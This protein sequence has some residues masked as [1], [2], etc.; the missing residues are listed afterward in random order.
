MNK[1]LVVFQRE[2]L[3]QVRSKSFLVT[4]IMM[5][6]LMAGSI[7]VQ[8]LVGDGVD[9]KDRSIAI[10][11]RTGVLFDSLKAQADARNAKDVDDENGKR[12]R[13]RFLLTS[14]EPAADATKQELDLSK[15]VK[16]KQLFAFVEI[17]AN[18]TGSQP[19]KDGDFVRYYSDSPTDRE[20][21]RWL[22]APLNQLALS[23]RFEEA[24]LSMNVVEGAIRPIDVSNLGLVTVDE[25]GKI[26]DAEEADRLTT[27]LVPYG[28]CMLMFM[29]VMVSGPQ[30]MQNIIEEKMQRIAEVLIGSIPPFQLMLG[31]L[32]G[33]MA[34]SLTLIGLYL[35]GGY[36]VADYYDKSDLLPLSQVVWM[37][38]YGLIAMLMFGSIFSAIGA[39]CSEIKDAQSLMMP[40]MIV[41]VLP[42][43][44]IVPVIQ[45][46]NSPLATWIS[47]FPPAT[48]M[49]MVTRLAVPPGIPLWQP[50]AGIPLVL[51]FSVLCV[52]A[53]G[54][55]FRIGL[56]SQGKAP[57]LG[58][59]MTWVVRG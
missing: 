18:L 1:V 3:A 51:V 55:V 44:L 39:A 16:N 19:S 53:A 36:V 45:A 20:F 54:R 59:L 17:G 2:Y 21:V 24:N 8:S 57:K 29:S 10:V 30:M 40:V 43:M 9:T 34:V 49:I 56:L 42:L 12:I 6:L 48:P 33:V 26:K 37:L 47:F 25:T 22:Y 14:I 7:L 15:R 52:F 50:I 46:P 38:V 41:V 28:F 35:A 58:E 4:L 32:L 23:K 27:F 13:P 5:P 31:K 11:D